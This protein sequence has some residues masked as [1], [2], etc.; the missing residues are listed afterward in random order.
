MGGAYHDWDQPRFGRPHDAARGHGG[1]PE[2]ESFGAA[3]ELELSV[4]DHGRAQLGGVGRIHPADGAGLGVL[5]EWR[6]YPYAQ[7]GYGEAA[8]WGEMDEKMRL[9][10]HVWCVALSS[11]DLLNQG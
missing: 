6:G 9:R 4:P 10:R 2:Y 1:Q 5:P 11:I 3:L 8:I 7:P